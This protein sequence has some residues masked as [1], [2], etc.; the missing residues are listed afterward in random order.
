MKNFI[1]ETILFDQKASV[2]DMQF[3]WDLINKISDLFEYGSHGFPAGQRFWEKNHITAD[4]VFY[5]EDNGPVFVHK[6]SNLK[7][8]IWT[9]EKK[10]PF[11]VNEIYHFQIDTELEFKYIEFIL[12]DLLE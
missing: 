11:I 1:S 8:G 2:G 6:S 5:N 9:G 10:V 7:K 3:P 12:S 4:G